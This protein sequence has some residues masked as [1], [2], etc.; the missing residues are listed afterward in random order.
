MLNHY[1][2]RLETLKEMVLNESHCHQYEI[3]LRNYGIAFSQPVIL[4]VNSFGKSLLKT[5][6][7]LQSSL[8]VN[9]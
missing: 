3:Q 4:I 7:S 5:M 8:S 1:I 9:S 6:V 2:C